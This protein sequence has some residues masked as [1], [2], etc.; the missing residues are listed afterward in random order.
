M[1]NLFNGVFSS[2][3]GSGYIPEMEQII[4]QLERG[5]LVTKFSW[6][7]KAERKTLAIR[8]ETRQ[9]TWSRPATATKSTFDGAVDWGEIKEVRLGKNSKD[10]DKWP[11]DSKK[12]ENSRCFVVFYGKE[13]KLR[14][15]SIAAECDLW[16]RGLRYLVKDTITAPY[17]LQVQR[18]LRRE[19]YAMENPRESINLK[20]LKCFLT[21]VNYKIPPSKLREIFNDVDTRKRAEI[22]FDDFA[23]LYHKIIF[24]ENSACEIF[25][26]ILQYSSNLKTVSLQEVE[27][28]FRN[29]QNDRIGNDERSVSQ[30]IC[31]FL[32]DPHREIQEPYLT[33]SEFLDFLF[34]K[35]NDLWDPNKDKVY[36]DMCKPLSH[37]W[38]S[39]SHNTYLTGDQF[40]SESSVEA[41]ARCLRMGCRCIELD[42]WDGPDGMPFIYHGHTLTTKIKF[43]DVIKTIKE[44]AFTTSEYPVILSIEDNCSLPQQRK[45]ATAMQFNQL[46][47]GETELPSP[48]SLR[49][50]ILLKHKKLPEGQEESSFLIK[51]DTSDMDLRSSVKNGIMYLEDPVDKEWNPH[52]FVL[53][54]NKLFYTDSYKPDQESERSEDEEDS[55]SFQRPKSN[56]PNEELHFSEKWFHGRLHNGREEAEQLLRAYSHLVTADFSI[57]LQEPVPQPNLHETE[58]WYHQNTKKNQA[59]EILRRV[60]TEGAFLVRPSENDANCYTISFRADRKI[61]HCRIKLEGRLYTIG[62]VEFESLVDLINYYENHPLYRRVKLTH[63]IS[64]EM[65]KRMAV[66]SSVNFIYLIYYKKKPK[67]IFQ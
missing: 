22:G 3:T 12:I 55:G 27:S 53:S 8:R 58:E 34:S 49:R 30:F 64:E 24:E 5:T 37:Y 54:H 2:S 18:W 60:K 50:K 26:K 13:F 17:P 61:K 46:K 52:F 15:L 6:R 19:F 63:A 44:H 47:K 7:K 10:F 45:M 57:V 11:E 31:D 1:F 40:S 67:I 38:I 25:D 39:S 4:S 28:F 35:Q 43:M 56:V 66:V 36:Q 41:Y 59:E 48:Y 20:D 21:R 16:I 42:C 23:T 32:K 14:V 33:T 62:N 9:I 51:N 29:E 65:V